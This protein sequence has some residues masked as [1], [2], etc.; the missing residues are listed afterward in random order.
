MWWSYI[1]I[2]NLQ[3]WEL[4]DSSLLLPSPHLSNLGTMKGAWS[5]EK[6]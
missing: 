2:R 3:M 5:P 4:H 1:E 6:T